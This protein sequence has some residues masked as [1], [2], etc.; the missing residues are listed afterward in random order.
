MQIRNEEILSIIGYD[1]TEELFKE[2][3]GIGDELKVL[4]DN[5]VLEKSYIGYRLRD[6]SLIPPV[7][8]I[9][10]TELHMDILQ[11]YYYKK[12]DQL[13]LLD[14]DDFYNNL[15]YFLNALYHINSLNN[16]DEAFKYI[17]KIAKKMVYWGKK[18]VLNE[19]LNNIPN[20]SLSKENILWKTYLDLFIQIVPFYNSHINEDELNNK[21]LLFKESKNLNKRLYCEALNLQGIFTRIY[22]KDLIKARSLHENVINLF[23]NIK[24]LEEED[25]LILGRTYENISFFYSK[26]ES[27]FSTKFLEKADEY[28][29]K[30]NDKYERLKLMYYK[31][32]LDYKNG[33]ADES[34]SK[35]VLNIENYLKDFRFPDIER[36]LYNTLSEYGLSREN[37]FESYFKIKTHVLDCDLALYQEYFISDF[38][39]IN[40]TIKRSIKEKKEQI[41][42]SINTLIDF[43]E[44]T[45]LKSECYFIKAVKCLLSNQEY[46]N[47]LNKVENEDLKRMFSFYIDY[48]NNTATV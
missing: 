11:T 33:M 38:L 24:D 17:L 18:D 48:I 1:I 27:K 39:R 3:I 42:D 6:K 36:N 15:H 13:T 10:K 29:Q 20:S 46:D 2:K 26:E 19:L 9:R 28:L 40:N 43:L 37:D 12:I 45:Q 23:E 47:D 16:Y 8:N 14:Y 34:L 31:F 21:F 41:T 35:H 7:D 4:V 44:K 32:V 22:L 5:G 25:Y 30:T